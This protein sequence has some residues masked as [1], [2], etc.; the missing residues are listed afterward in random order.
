MISLTNNL[1]KAWNSGCKKFKSI[2]LPQYRYAHENVDKI[3]V[4]NKLDQ[5]EKRRVSYDEGYN[6]AKNH[7][8]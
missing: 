5:V 4:G 2:Q 7:G 6:F 3:M 8:I 1:L